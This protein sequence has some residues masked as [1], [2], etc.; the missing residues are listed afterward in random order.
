MSTPDSSA[1]PRWGIPSVICSR[2][3][4]AYPLCFNIIAC[5]PGKCRCPDRG[6]CISTIG[7]RAFPVAA[8]RLW[9]TLPLNVTSES[10]MSVFTKRLRTHIFSVI[11]SRI[12]CS[13]CTVTVISHTIID[14][15]LFTKRVIGLCYYKIITL[16][17]GLYHYYWKALLV[18]WFILYAN[19][20]YDKQL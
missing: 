4:S 8:A 6:T 5:C 9:N 7:D 17:T 10:S 18:S 13:A 16:I 14:T 11:L 3:P 19:Y 1:V 15:Y 20:K 12:S 2:G